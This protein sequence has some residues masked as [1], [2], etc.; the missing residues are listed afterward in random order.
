MKNENIWKNFS[1]MSNMADFKGNKH[2][3]CIID[4]I[5]YRESIENVEFNQKR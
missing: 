5:N 2:L 4:K 3:K 1:D